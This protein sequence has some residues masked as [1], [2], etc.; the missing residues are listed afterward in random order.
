M[1][2][3]E[4]KLE[5]EN[6]LLIQAYISRRMFPKGKKVIEYTNSQMCKLID[7][8]IHSAKYRDILKDRFIDGLTFEQIAELR[9]I[10]PRQVQNI[11]YR[12]QDELIKFLPF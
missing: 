4:S 6:L 9:D 5:N 11:V 3:D 1:V 12:A 8:H 10:S 2:T 7:E